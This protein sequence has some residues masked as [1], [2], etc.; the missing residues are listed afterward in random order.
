MFVGTSAN[1]F[2]PSVD[3]V[4][5][6]AGAEAP[7]VEIEVSLVIIDTDGIAAE[8]LFFDR[9]LW[10]WLDDLFQALLALAGVH[11]DA[12]QLENHVNAAVGQQT[13]R[14]TAA[15]LIS[16]GK[17]PCNSDSSMTNT[18]GSRLLRARPKRS[19]ASRLR[20]GFAQRFQCGECCQTA[21]LDANAPT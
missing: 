17:W 20:V 19:C 14:S 10:A 2:E 6:D 5:R 7:A 18:T 12:Q 16:R 3:G 15:S 1:R 9:D 21:N 4:D 13:K 11:D 8:Q